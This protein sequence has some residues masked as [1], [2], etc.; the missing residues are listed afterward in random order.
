VAVSRALCAFAVIFS[1]ALAP[2][3]LGQGNSG[4]APNKPTVQNPPPGS[5]DATYT[6]PKG[7]AYGFYC[8]GVSKKHVKGQKGTPFS[9]CVKAMKALATGKTKSPAKA[10]KALSKKKPAKVKGSNR[11]GKSPYAKC[12]SGAKKLL[13]DKKKPA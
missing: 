6:I 9:Q 12:V 5:P 1:L 3:A 11:R 13:K 10:C 2:T 7:H 8:Q 4:T